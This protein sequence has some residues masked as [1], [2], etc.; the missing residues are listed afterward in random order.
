[1]DYGGCLGWAELEK[2]FGPNFG[3]GSVKIGAIHTP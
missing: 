1:M 3:S 2:Y